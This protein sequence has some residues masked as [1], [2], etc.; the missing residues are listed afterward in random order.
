MGKTSFETMLNR[1]DRVSNGVVEKEK[2]DG[3]KAVRLL[4]AV[5]S[6]ARRR[7]KERYERSKCG[8]DTL[9]NESLERF[10]KKVEQEIADYLAFF[11]WIKENESQHD[12]KI[13]RILDRMAKNFVTLAYAY[14][15]LL[16]DR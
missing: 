1:V 6:H 5:D 16:R 11:A 4:F 14:Q 13:H 3:V 8:N 2:V 9:G 10:L 12:R 15:A 7:I